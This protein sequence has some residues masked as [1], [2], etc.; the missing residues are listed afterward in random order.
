M[1]ERTISH[2]Q[3]NAF[4]SS[5]LNESPDY[6]IVSFKVVKKCFGSFHEPLIEPGTF[7]DEL[8]IARL[9]LLFKNGSN[10]DLENYTP[11][12]FLYCFSKIFEKIV[13][14]HLYK[15]LHGS[16]ILHRKKFDFIQP[17]IW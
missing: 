11:I 7:P 1:F 8:K 4:F 6:D 2:E 10:L 3:N 12:S 9:T 5:K 14:S 17:S 16:N 13:N 15:H